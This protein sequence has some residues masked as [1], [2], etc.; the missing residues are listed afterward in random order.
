MWE[1]MT[2]DE[3]AQRVDELLGTIDA[4]LP[5]HETGPGIAEALQ[6]RG[7][8]TFT[9][10][11][12]AWRYGGRIVAARV[13]EDD[14]SLRAVFVPRDDADEAYPGQERTRLRT[15]LRGDLSAH[16]AARDIGSFLTFEN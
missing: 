4:S 5:P 1:T 15:Y 2:L 3:W 16:D 8:T 12:P 13:A 11:D 10:Q 9:P 6:A 14:S 7:E